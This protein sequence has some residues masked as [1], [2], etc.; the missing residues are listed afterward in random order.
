MLETA[1]SD[2]GLYAQWWWWYWAF[3]DELLFR[4]KDILNGHNLD[5][6][7]LLHGHDDTRN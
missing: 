5:K 4:A 7:F 6:E 2:N 1:P 3:T